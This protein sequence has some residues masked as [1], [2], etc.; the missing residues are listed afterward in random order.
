M[1]SI[2][3]NV[4]CMNQYEHTSYI[5]DVSISANIPYLLFIISSS[6]ILSVK[7]NISLWVNWQ[8]SYCNSENTG[9]DTGVTLRMLF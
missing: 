3:I 5:S 8:C 6:L 7:Q 9:M 4:L 2:G 1:M